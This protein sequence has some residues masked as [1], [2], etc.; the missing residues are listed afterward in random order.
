MKVTLRTKFILSYLLVIA[1]TVSVVSLTIRHFTLKNFTR[2]SPQFMPQQELDRVLRQARP[3]FEAMDD[4]LWWAALASG[5]LAIGIGILFSE[6]ILKPIKH[7]IQAT[8]QIA[9]GKYH[10][11]VSTESNDEIG[12]L[13]IALNEMAEQ[14]GRV[15]QFRRDMVANVSHELSTPLTSIGGYIEAMIDGL[16]TGEKETQ[17]T[18]QLI[19]DETKRLKQMVV[20]VRALSTIDAP[21]FKLNRQETD[22]N[23]LIKKTIKKLKPQLQGKSLILKAEYEKSLPKVK[24][25]RDRFAQVIIN[26]MSNAMRFTPEKGTLT[27]KTKC[28]K[29]EV[30]MELMDTG[31]GIPSKDL[32]HIF[33]RFYRADKSRQRKTGGTGIGLSIV[34]EIVEAHHGSIHVKS[35]PGKGTLFTVKLPQGE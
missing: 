10:H 3:F 9:K 14:L 18:L 29:K 12:E 21:N 20:E 6:R 26:L 7:V 19:Q 8:K 22:L 1:V 11:K 25:D 15:D 27:L 28:T 5:I 16:I 24:V 2:F 4:S 34:K 23:A 33:E 13:A 35:D 31:I 30:V 32:P 17:K